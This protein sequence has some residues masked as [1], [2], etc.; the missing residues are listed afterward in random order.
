MATAKSGRKA[1]ELY[2]EWTNVLN[3]PADVSAALA[4][5]AEAR[6]ALR[7]AVMDNAAE[8]LRVWYPAKDAQK[9]A[10]EVKAG[11]LDLKATRGFGGV[12][13]I[14]LAAPTGS[15]KSK[16]VKAAPSA[17]DILAKARTTARD[18]ED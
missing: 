12:L 11:R 18:D 17:A 15:G 1:A 7:E 14:A 6:T 2:T 5:I 16:S 9:I 4:A 3:P 10:G 8:L 13:S